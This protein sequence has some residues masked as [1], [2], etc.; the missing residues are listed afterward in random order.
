[1]PTG[2]LSQVGAPAAPPAPPVLDPDSPAIGCRFQS[3][4]SATS[5]NRAVPGGKL[6]S[7]EPRNAFSGGA[8]APSAAMRGWAAQRYETGS[9]QAELNV[10][11]TASANRRRQAPLSNA[12]SVRRTFNS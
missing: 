5:S 6:R 12:A 7:R 3:K 1:M 11:A 2:A 8:Q 9:P 10:V 4:S